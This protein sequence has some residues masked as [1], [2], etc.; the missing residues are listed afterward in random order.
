MVSLIPSGATAVTGAMIG[1]TAIPYIGVLGTPVIDGGTL[2]VVA[3][4]AEQNATYFPHRLHALD[5]TNGKELLSGPVLVSDQIC[6][7]CISCS[8]PAWQLRRS[9]LR[10]LR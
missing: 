4:T 6:N 7:L 3:E 10:G 8:A 2:Y 5:I 9:R 1:D